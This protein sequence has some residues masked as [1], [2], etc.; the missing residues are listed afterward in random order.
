MAFT[1]AINSVNSWL[2]LRFHLCLYD[3]TRNSAS[4][5][6]ARQWLALR[7]QGTSAGHCW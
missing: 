6:K 1:A 2:V 5:W 3:T 4:N 7:F